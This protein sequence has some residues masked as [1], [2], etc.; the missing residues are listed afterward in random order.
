[1]NDFLPGHFKLISEL[2]ASLSEAER[3]TLVRLLGKI[4]DRVAAIRAESAALTSST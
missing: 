4:Q 3:K 1:M 2:M